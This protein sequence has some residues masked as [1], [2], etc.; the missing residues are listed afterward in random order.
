[1]T[2]KPIASLTAI[3]IKMGSNIGGSSM[4]N[5]VYA[6]GMNRRTSLI[7]QDSSTPCGAVDRWC[8]ILTER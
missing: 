2:G 7:N 6:G 1:M 5:N 4:R 3:S 8:K